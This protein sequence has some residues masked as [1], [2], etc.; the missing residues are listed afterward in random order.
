MVSGLGT[1][2]MIA[3]YGAPA[4]PRPRRCR[5]RSE[6]RQPAGAG[7][8]RGAVR[9]RRHH[10]SSRAR[11][12]RVGRWRKLLAVDTI[13]LPALAERLG[14]A[15][16]AA[17]DRRSLHPIEAAARCRA[18]LRANP[19]WFRAAADHAAT[20][21]GTGRCDRRVAG[22]RRRRARCARSVWPSQRRRGSPCPCVLVGDRA[23]GQRP[24]RRRR[25]HRCGAR[26]RPHGRRGRRRCRLRAAAGS[27][28]TNSHCCARW[29]SESACT[30]W[31]R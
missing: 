24:R 13:A 14:A 12:S 5:R 16:L 30:P 17:A 2:V 10:R 28:S 27:R 3:P 20:A 31:L 7:H 8:D 25:R 11:H 1:R 18:V 6:A 23:D 29:Q 22:A 26:R 4:L 19:G 21:D 15:R 9:A